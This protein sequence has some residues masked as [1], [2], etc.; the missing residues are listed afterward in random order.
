MENRTITS[1]P[2]RQ[3]LRTLFDDLHDSLLDFDGPR[4]VVF[5]TRALC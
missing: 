1:K 4:G 5:R 3:I 2:S